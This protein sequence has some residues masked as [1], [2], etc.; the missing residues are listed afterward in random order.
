MKNL[1][2]GI[3]QS[4]NMISYL[5]ASATTLTEFYT[6]TS[7]NEEITFIDTEEGNAPRKLNSLYIENVGD[8]TMFIQPIPSK[9][10]L[11]IPA[12]SD[13]NYDLSEVR[14]IKVLGNSGQKL[15]WSGLFF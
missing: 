10:L 5:P 7:A 15:R 1:S 12:H 11:C 9:Y 8:T 6:T 14:G 2:I 3:L 13:R 4:S